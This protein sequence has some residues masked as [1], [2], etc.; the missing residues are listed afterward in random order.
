MIVHMSVC[1]C[2]FACFSITS[3]QKQLL[4]PILFPFSVPVHKSPPAAA[5]GGIPHHWESGIFSFHIMYIKNVYFGTAWLFQQHR[6]ILKVNAVMGAR[7]CF[8]FQ[9]MRLR[10]VLEQKGYVY[11]VYFSG[12]LQP[13]K[14]LRTT[15]ARRRRSQGLFSGKYEWMDQRIEGLNG[16]MKARYM[17]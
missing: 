5:A 4:S 15:A 3:L 17:G 7:W 8:F 12:W 13:F 16:R 2:V 6:R 14:G 10:F 11:D 1:V 9:Q